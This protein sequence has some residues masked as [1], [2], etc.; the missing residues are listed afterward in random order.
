MVVTLLV[1]LSSGCQSGGSSSDSNVSANSATSTSTSNTPSA[2]P[3]SIIPAA[4]TPV[5]ALVPGATDKPNSSEQDPN[6][7]VANRKVPVT[8]KAAA[9]FA[10]RVSFGMTA[11]EQ[12]N[13]I[14]KGYESWLE[15]Q[16]ALTDT[17]MTTHLNEAN[18]QFNK[19]LATSSNRE[20]QAA[21]WKTVLT[22]EDQ[23]R[24]RVAF[25]LSQIFVVSAQESS[26]GN[27]REQG[28]ANYYDM[29]TSHAFGNFRDLLEDVTLHPMMGRYL[30]MYRNRKP[31]LEKNRHPDENYARE[32]MQLFTIGLVELNLNGTPKTN[33]QGQQI[34]TYTQDDI[35][36]LA[37]V[38]TGWTT[39]G[40][41]QQNTFWPK[42]VDPMVLVTQPMEAYEKEHDAQAKTI[43]GNV[44]IGAGLTAKQELDIALDTLFNHPNVGP[45]IGKQLIQRL[46]TSNPT[47]AYVER[48]ARVFN[49]NGKGQR[50]DLKA[51]VKAVLMDNE[52]INGYQTMPNTFGKVKEPLI[53]QA[54]LW[55]VLGAH[56]QSGVFGFN[57]ANNYFNQ[58]ALGA[59]TVFNFYRPDFQQN[60]QLRKNGLVT[61]EL[62]ITDENQMT[63][64][65]NAIN[66][67]LKNNSQK[68][69]AKPTDVLVDLTDELALANDA[70]A[71][72]S[73]L[74]VLLLGGS[75]P[76]LMKQTLTEYINTL[77]KS[78]RERRVFDAIY[79]IATSAEHAIQQ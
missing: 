61:P 22:N 19:T 62:Q 56:T 74:D 57:H 14:D 77:P 76:A 28:L 39:P 65:A 67:A 13:V 72:V 24:Q 23:L 7:P 54:Q 58:E 63:G 2:S 34:A 8:P 51:V 26:L 43:L 16:F 40:A 60:G 18:K 68:S 1:L 11:A 5:L 10:N 4:L 9:R 44:K 79:M 64:F 55:R 78:E 15:E 70:A 71:L 73:H 53:R 46:V 36:G 25:A 12:Q 35:E 37:H 3:V 32:I 17:S 52:A 59:D 42:N 41:N 31:D 20:L 50:G 21:W 47:P 66:A 75:M 69:S 45:F 33:S 49:N 38:F 6:N 30:S 27:Y 48:V 29:L